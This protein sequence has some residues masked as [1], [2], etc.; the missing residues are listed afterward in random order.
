[1]RIGTLL[2]ATLILTQA[3]CSSQQA[4][5]GFFDSGSSRPE[6]LEGTPKKYPQSAYLL[7]RGT[8]G[9]EA[10]AGDRARGDLA[11]IFEVRVEVVTGNITTVKQSGGREAVSRQSTQQVSAKTDK[12]IN[13]INVVETWRDPKTQEVHAL[14]V[15]SRSQATASLEED[16]GRIDAAVRLEMGKA[17]ATS[18]PLL[19]IGALTHAL[20][21]VVKRD[22]FQAMLK[23]IDRAGVGIPA[24]VSQAEI[25]AR[26]DD[27][28]KGVQVAPSVADDAGMSEFAGVLKGG[29]AAAGF[30]AEDAARANLLLVGRLNLS[31]LGRRDGWYWVRG[32]L[33]ISLVE[34]DS[35]RVR[36]SRTWPLKAAGQEASTAKS[37]V[38]QEA[39]KVLKEELRPTIVAFASS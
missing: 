33:E 9:S 12:V 25:R 16:I 3:A 15:L 4:G 5:A 27:T 39:E 34:R 26:I 30:L 23:V 20:D 6:W 37:R 35:G 28:V 13:G 31:D 38:L 32:T 11:K 10:D 14:A 21:T 29:L 2:L 24:P 8:A 36:G 19:K 22:G 18:D 1:M 7:G 17:N